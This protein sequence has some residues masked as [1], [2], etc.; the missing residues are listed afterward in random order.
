MLEL[1]SG[2]EFNAL[3]GADIDFASG[4]TTLLKG[5]VDLNGNDARFSFRISTVADADADVGANADVWLIPKDLSVE[6]DYTLDKTTH[7][8]VEGQMLFIHRGGPTLNEDAVIRYESGAQA[9]RIA[10]DGTDGGWVIFI[11]RNLDLNWRP[12]LWGGNADPS[13]IAGTY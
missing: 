2:S 5:L 11:Y 4:T 8:P 13:F 1:R 7:L 12:L 10:G 3:N 6:R 9:C